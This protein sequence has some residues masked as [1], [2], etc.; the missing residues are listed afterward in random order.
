MDFLRCTAAFSV[1]L[2]HVLGPFR[3]LYG[4]I[5]NSDWL[6][7]ARIN[8]IR[9]W[10]VPLFMMISG[11][12]LLSTKPPFECDHYL[13]KRL[14][15]VPIPFIG[16]TIIYALVGGFMV[17]GVFNATWS[18]DKTIEIIE[19]SPNDTCLVSFMILFRFTL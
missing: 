17:E 13:S 3:H 5:P 2:I 8:S 9:R 14:S 15:K 12:L 19:H 18:L 1:V 11:A 6:G 16:L 4:E 7:A 10:A